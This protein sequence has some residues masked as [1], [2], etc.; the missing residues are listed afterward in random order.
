MQVRLDRDYESYRNIKYFT[1]AVESEGEYFTC[2]F[3][4]KYKQKSKVNR[5]KGDRGEGVWWWA[6]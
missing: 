2:C 4:L 6:M 1:G 3:C 5:E